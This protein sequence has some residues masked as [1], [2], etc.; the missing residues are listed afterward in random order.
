MSAAD[1][2]G[3]DLDLNFPG[4]NTR[5]RAV[6]RFVSW[7]A[8]RAPRVSF[9]KSLSDRTF[10]V[11]FCSELGESPALREEE[12]AAV[13]DSVFPVLLDVAPEILLPPRE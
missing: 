12:D 2:V 5:C 13:V 11:A 7:V 10:L 6:V 1:F 4:E 3:V 8:V 9:D